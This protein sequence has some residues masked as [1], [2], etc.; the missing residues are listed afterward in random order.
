MVTRRNG[1]WYKGKSVNDRYG[2]IS[3]EELLVAIGN[4]TFSRGETE[5]LVSASQR[6]R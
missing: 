1:H 4:M 2:S 5:I 3:D 6:K